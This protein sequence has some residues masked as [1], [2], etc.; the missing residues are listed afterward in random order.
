MGDQRTGSVIYDVLIVGGGPAG[1]TCGRVLARGGARVA[2]LDRAQFPRVKLCGGWISAPIWDA[3]A[4]TPGEYPGGLWEWQTCH[5]SYG[6]EARAIPCHGWFIRRFELDDFLLRRSGAELHLGVSVQDIGRDPDGD[7]PWSVAGLRAR[8]L[9]GAGGTHCPV[10]RLLAPKRPSG[11]VGVQEHEFP[12]D[13]AAIARTRAGRDGEPELL[14]HDDLRGYSWNVPKT[15]WLNLGSGT[16]EP[17]EVRAAWQRARHHF[18]AAGHVPDEAG[19]ALDAMKGHTYYLFDPAHLDGAARD[20]VL[21]CGDSL[22]LAQPLTAEGILPAVLSG[23][24]A[25]EAILAGAPAS[26]P[27]RLGAHPVMADYRRVF[28]AR[29]AAAALGRRS[30]GGGPPRSRLARQAVARGFAWMFSGARL[31]APRLVD[32]GLALAERWADRHRDEKAAP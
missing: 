25:A 13:P 30:T 22:G 11:P 19:A 24:L 6:G 3:L 16:V 12:A 18:S 14:L 7:G 15:D 21:L 1:S 17:H 23:R 26:Y 4:L 10:A 27:A 2:I 8:Y 9:V 29:E 20:N 31:P 5:V 32:A 28:R